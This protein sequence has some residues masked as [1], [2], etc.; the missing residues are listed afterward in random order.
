MADRI[1]TPEQVGEKLGFS[2][3]SVVDFWRAWGL[4][5]YKVG[6]QLRFRESEIDKWLSGRKAD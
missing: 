5:A 6:K 4:P 3:K 1:L 2:K